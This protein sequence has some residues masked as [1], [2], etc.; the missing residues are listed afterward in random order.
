MAKAKTVVTHK[1]KEEGLMLYCIKGKKASEV[2]KILNVATNTVEGWV[3]KGRWNLLR[4]ENNN[5]VEYAAEAIRYINE[6]VKA[7]ALFRDIA[8]AR[9]KK[10][11]KELS[12]YDLKA[13]LE[14]VK[15]ADK[16][17]LDYYALKGVGGNEF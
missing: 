7:Y 5:G 6:S 11:G 17:I 8:V 9:T 3:S 16:M 1:M 14:I 10:D 4:I 15:I 12:P 2:A 13:L